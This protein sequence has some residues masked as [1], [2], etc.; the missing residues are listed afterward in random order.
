MN[1]AA[2]TTTSS[3][4]FLFKGGAVTTF[5]LTLENL[6]DKPS[7]EGVTTVFITL[8]TETYTNPADSRVLLR[9]GHD[10]YCATPD[11]QMLILAYEV[12]RVPPGALYNTA[13][14]TAESFIGRGK[15][16]LELSL[17]HI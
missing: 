5:E 15:E 11:F 6:L 3:T 7:P 14:A 4:N 17:I 12:V 10:A 16:A 13:K 1:Q 9:Q 8:D 2:T